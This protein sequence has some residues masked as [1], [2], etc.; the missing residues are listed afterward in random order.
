MIYSYY[1][2][3]KEKQVLM[4]CSNGEI[5]IVSYISKKSLTVLV[6]VTSLDHRLNIILLL[7]AVVYT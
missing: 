6:L 7:S 1:Y 4:N 5:F 2:Y 3:S